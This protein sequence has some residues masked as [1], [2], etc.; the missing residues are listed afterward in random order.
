MFIDLKGSDI[1]NANQTARA[2]FMTI[3]TIYNIY[4]LGFSLEIRKTSRYAMFI[5]SRLFAHVST[6]GVRHG[7]VT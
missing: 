6:I 7:R 5:Q 2:C 4:T 1:Q 3:P